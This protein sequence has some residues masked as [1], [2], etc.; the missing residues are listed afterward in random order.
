MRSM[1]P[2]NCLL[3]LTGEYKQQRVRGS[4]E[5]YIATCIFEVGCV[6][7]VL[8]YSNKYFVVVS[9]EERVEKNNKTKNSTTE[10][11]CSMCSHACMPNTNA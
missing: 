5:Q 6:I 4:P 9:I 11:A 8:V 10:S 3:H 7:N 2:A 1:V